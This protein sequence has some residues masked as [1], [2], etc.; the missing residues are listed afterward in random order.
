MGIEIVFENFLN[1]LTTFFWSVN[2]CLKI[3][4]NDI[5]IFDIAIGWWILTFAIAG[6]IVSKIGGED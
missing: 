2:Q 3:F 1:F 6:L 4:F 5:V